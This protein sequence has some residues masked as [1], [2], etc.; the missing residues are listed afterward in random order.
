MMKHLWIVLV[1]V[2]AACGTEGPPGPTGPIGARGPAGPQGMPG[3]AL[4]STAYCDGDIGALI[5][6]FETYMFND[7]SSMG[8]CSVES[9]GAEVA[10]VNMWRAGTPNAARARCIVSADSDGSPSFGFWFFDIV[11]PLRAKATYD[12]PGSP[13]HGTV[14][15][16]PCTVF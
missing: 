12:D 6:G 7:G 15:D 9:A 5:L 16:M 1:L 8:V 13:G 14:V 2:V 10:S 11:A 3:M 4:V